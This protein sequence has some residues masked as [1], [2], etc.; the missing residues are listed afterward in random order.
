MLQATRMVQ[1]AIP[2]LFFSDCKH[3]APAFTSDNRE[4]FALVC[5]LRSSRKEYIGDERS[6][7]EGRTPENIRL[8]R[9][10]EKNFFAFPCAMMVK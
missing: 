2:V 9:A 3:Q 8:K 5:R 1:E 10:R 4:W 6:V 7:G